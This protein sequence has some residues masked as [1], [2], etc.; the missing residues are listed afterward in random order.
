MQREKGYLKDTGL[1]NANSVNENETQGLTILCMAAEVRLPRLLGALAGLTQCSENPILKPPNKKF[2]EALGNIM[3]RSNLETRLAWDSK[4]WV[5]HAYQK[6]GIKFLL[7]HAAAGLLFSPG[8]GKTAITLAAFKILKKAKRASKMLVIAPLKP[9][10][11]VWPKEVV[12]WTDFHGLRIVVL[13][14]PKKDEALMEDADVYVINSEGLPWLLD[15]TK[16]KTRAGRTR[17]DVNP[18]AFAKL[19]FD[20]LCID[21][22]SKMKHPNTSRFKALKQVLHTF[23]RRWGLTGSPS[24]NGLM[25]LFGEC[26]VLDLGKALGPYITHYRNQF[27]TQ[28]DKQGFVWVP[29]KGSEAQIYARLK[30]LMLRFGAE[31]YL[32]MPD[33]IEHDIS[34]E[35]PPVARELYDRLEDAMIAAI[36]ERVVTAANAAVASN[37]CSQVAAGGIYLDPDVAPLLR[38][39]KGKR[40]WALIHDEKTDALEDLIDELQG[41]QLLIAYEY[42]HDLERIAARFK[43]AVTVL[44]KGVSPKDMVEYERAWNAGEIVNLAIQPASGAHGLNLQGASAAHVCWYTP[45]WNYELYDQ[46]VRRLRR[47]GTNATRIWS[48]RIIAKDTVDEDRVAA[49][50]RKERGQNALFAALNARIIKRRK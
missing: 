19:G 34:V 8:M 2:L 3:A 44:G 33:L 18:A 49:L 9:C 50:T 46:L 1:K 31:D 48:H 12:K 47:Q 41:Q 45:T 29:K 43:A 42:N 39:Q 21:E 23:K 5:P 25:D 11:L 14:G 35:L 24:A 15:S 7:E 10:Y 28:V 27:F 4:P 6:R 20:T 32:D 16:T 36:D 22:L 30:P 26:Y 37:K 38:V 40:E 17:V 13:H